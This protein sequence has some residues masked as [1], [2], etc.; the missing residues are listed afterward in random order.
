MATAKAIKK[1]G[2]RR[3]RLKLLRQMTDA[4][5]EPM[6]VL[7]FVWLALLI[8][9]FT[10]GLGRYGTI[11]SNVIWGLFVVHFLLEFTLAPQKWTYLKQNWITAIALVLPALR[12]FRVF[13]ALRIL[14][15]AGRSLSLL[16]LLTS[17]NR[18]M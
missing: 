17:L 18:G 16:R 12:I 2:V 9:D 8:F 1:E 7:A 4:L 3:E 14:A 10:Y 11:A 13:Q 5:D 15:H 6:T